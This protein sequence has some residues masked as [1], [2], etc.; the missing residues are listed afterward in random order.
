VLALALLAVVIN[1]I[2]VSLQTSPRRQV[3]RTPPPD[4]AWRAVSG[5]EG[6]T[7]RLG[8]GRTSERSSRAA[9]VAST[10]LFE[11]L[12]DA[13]VG[14]HAVWLPDLLSNVPAEVDRCTTHNNENKK[15]SWERCEFILDE[16]HNLIS[17]EHT[18]QHSPMTW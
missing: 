14:L 12:N 6:S 2:L 7:W 3:H 11:E 18:S 4:D 5:D 8:D 17:H 10:Y 15:S 9:G 16:R 1:F 13:V